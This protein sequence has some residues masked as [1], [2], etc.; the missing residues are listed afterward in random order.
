MG[1]VAKRGVAFFFLLILALLAGGALSI[2][3]VYESQTL[4]YKVGFD[5]TLLRCGQMAG[6]AAAVSIFIQILLGVRGRLLEEIFGVARLTR[7]HRINGLVLASFGLIH[8]TLILLVEEMRTLFALKS[9]PEMVGASLLLI[10]IANVF[11]S[12]FRRQVGMEYAHWRLMHRLLAYLA[13][14]L[15]AIHVLFVSDSFAQ[16]LPRVGLFTILAALAAAILKIKPLVP[17]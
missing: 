10:I 4:W 14:M 6:L 3:F 11:F 1:Q 15:L 5:K 16:G 17:R 12:L 7:W 9:W 2:P 8:V 13:P